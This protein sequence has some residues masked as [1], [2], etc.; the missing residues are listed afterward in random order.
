M[1]KVKPNILILLTGLI[2]LYASF[3]LI[4]RAY[5]W[6]SLM[7]DNQLYWGL[8][9]AFTFAIIKIYLIFRKLTIKNINR[10]QSINQSKIS[11]W[12]FHITKDKILI[13][14][15]IVFGSTLRHTPSIPKYVLFPIYLG[16]GIAMCYVWILYLKTFLNMNQAKRKS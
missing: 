9:I 5:T 1:P 4:K 8:M 13:I 16:I 10:I 15:M 7:T 6:V 11:I 3:M 2:W 14:L 12:E